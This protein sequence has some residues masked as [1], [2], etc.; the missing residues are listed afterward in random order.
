MQ[1]DDTDYYESSD[2]SSSDDENRIVAG[3]SK[4]NRW[5]LNETKDHDK[6]N[7]QI[8]AN[9]SKLISRLF[10]FKTSVSAGCV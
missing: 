10:Q 7:D 8:A 4:K 9:T 5:N 1:D 2:E 3:G 6:M